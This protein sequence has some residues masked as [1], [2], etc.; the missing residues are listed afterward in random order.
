MDGNESV[1]EVIE[2]LPQQ[3][4]SVSN[5]PEEIAATMF[6]LY[7]P[8]FQAAVDRLSNKALRRVLK[9][10]IEY[11]LVDEEYKFSTE[12]EKDTFFVA[13]RLILAKMMMIQ[14]TLFNNE[15]LL[16][17]AEQ[18]D[19]LETETKTENETNG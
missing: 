11:P 3:S 8:R 15:E 19:S 14:H 9:A 1:A 12:L 5:N 16:Q 13:E 17:G 2:E 6:T 4:Q 7:L 10:L 18:S